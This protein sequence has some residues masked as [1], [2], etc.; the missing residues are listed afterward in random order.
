MAQAKNAFPVGSQGLEIT[1][2]E[3]MKNLFSLS[4]LIGLVLGTTSCGKS[5]SS[6]EDV[7]TAGRYMNKGIHSLW[8]DNTDSRLIANEDD[9]VGPN[10]KDY[11]PLE[12][13]DLDS[14]YSSN[15]SAIAQ[16]KSAISKNLAN[17]ERFKAPSQ[18]LASIFQTLH[19]DTDDHVVRTREDLVGVAKIANYLKKNPKA[20]LLIEGHTDE[21]ASAAYNMALGMRRANHIRVLLIKQGVDKSRVF[22]VSCGKEKPLA[23]GA[24]MYHLNRRA[25]FKISE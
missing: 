5:N 20:S 16:P 25:E 21:R 6:W 24:N 13:S 9:F 11:I 18:S 1:S 8:G 4:L 7:K 15:E 19:F 3:F 12:D 2:E 17:L 14:Q 23:A 10:E 22:T